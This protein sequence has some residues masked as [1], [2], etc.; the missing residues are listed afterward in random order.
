MNIKDMTLDELK[1]WRA[2]VEVYGTSAEMYEVCELIAEK[3][4]QAKT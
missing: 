1:A 3:D 4:T 2:V